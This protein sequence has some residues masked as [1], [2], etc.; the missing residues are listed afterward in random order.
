MD[1]QSG[2]RRSSDTGTGRGDTGSPR[3]GSQYRSVSTSGI[4]A[5]TEK[6][7]ADNKGNIEAVIKEAV[8]GVKTINTLLNSELPKMVK[9]ANSSILGVAGDLSELMKELHTILAAVKRGEGAL[10][11][12]LVDQQLGKDMEET[13]INLK[14][15]TE[16]LLAHPL[17][18]PE[19]KKEGMG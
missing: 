5:E 2:C 3:K 18:S 1:S 4:L 8:Q 11:K 15:I 19:K 6:L 13:I 7:I 17:L 16:K 12:A 14:K 10:G 9:N